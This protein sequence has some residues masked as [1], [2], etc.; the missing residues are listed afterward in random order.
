[1]NL[2]NLACAL[3]FPLIAAATANTQVVT[4]KS[5]QHAIGEDVSF[6]PQAEQQGA[7]FRENGVAKPGLEIPR[8][9]SY[10]WVRLHIFVAPMTLPNNL[11]YTFD[12]EGNVL[13]VISVYDRY[14]RRVTSTCIGN[15]CS[16]I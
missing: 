12:N 4:G 10:N 14:A 15:E 6:L 16:I 5:S 7:V 11:G 9:H 3:F 13:P 8:D 1:M 2:R